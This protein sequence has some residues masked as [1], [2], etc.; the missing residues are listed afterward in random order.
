[1]WLVWM[2]SNIMANDVDS[3]IRYETLISLLCYALAPLPVFSLIAADVSRLKGFA[4]AYLVTTIVGGGLSLSTALA[5]V[6]I[7]FVDLTHDPVLSQ[8]GAGIP[9]W[10]IYV[11]GVL[12]Y[13]WFAYGFANGII[14][15]LALL[16]QTRRNWGYVIL[17][18]AAVV[19]AYF[20]VISDSKQAMG[21]TA[22][23]VLFFGAW[24]AR[25][26]KATSL[27]RLI[28]LV[29]VVVATSVGVFL[30]RPDLVLRSAGSFTEAFDVVSDRGSYWTEG[31]DAFVKSPLWGDGFAGSPSLGH[32]FFINT[33][34]NQGLVGMVFLIGF[35]V[36]FGNQVRGIWAGWGT[37][38]QALWRMAF[39]CLALFSLFVAQISGSPVS[40]WPL[41]WSA[42]I[43]WRMRETIEQPRV[44]RMARAPARQTPRSV[45][46]SA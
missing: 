31:W 27:L 37:R 40:A 42:I 9:H 43:L 12:N 46:Q 18:L 44:S 2:L 5:G 13:H 20:L 3:T 17:I 19:C 32:N 36:F 30:M 26:G 24:A 29:G 25:Q 15:I 14:F 35:L 38:E 28:L 45:R 22:L 8:Y 16:Q 21:G 39:L 11:M 7:S 1:M 23:T 6:G 10:V 34:A 4:L 33:L 41:F